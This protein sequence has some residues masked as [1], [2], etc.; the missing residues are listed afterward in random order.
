[1]HRIETAV[2]INASSDAI[3]SVLMDFQS[4]PDWNPFIQS[5]EGRAEP[6]SQLRILLKPPG[7]RGVRLA[8]HVLVSEPSR[9]FRWRGSL[10]ISG[11]FDAEHCFKLESLSSGGVTVHQDE[12]FFGV[13]VPLLRRSLDGA[14]KQGFIQMNESLKRRVENA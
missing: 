1:M 6:G 11:L 7:S 9:E 8:P 10:F 5:I 4:Y 2:V 14:T 3:W 13:L 12:T